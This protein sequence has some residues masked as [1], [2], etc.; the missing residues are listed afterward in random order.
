MTPFSSNRDPRPPMFLVSTTPCRTIGENLGESAY[1]YYFVLEAL[2]P[3]SIAWAAGRPSNGPSPASLS[4][5][6]E[7]D[8]FRPIHL[9]L[10][11]P[12]DAYFFP[13]VPNVLFP[14]WE[15]PEVPNRDFGLDVRPRTGSVPAERPT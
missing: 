1:S 5:R 9:V 4:R 13:S 10:N 2:A 6:A 8:G 3:A 12:Q 14:F 15:F 11:P 7:A